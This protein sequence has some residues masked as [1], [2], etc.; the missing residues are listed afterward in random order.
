[1]N[2]L[3]F[4]PYLYDTVPGQRF[5][6]EQWARHLERQGIHC[7]F[8]PFETAALK[9]VLYE[10]RHFET[11]LKELGYS[12][13]RR[14]GQMTRRWAKWDL[15]YLYRELLPVGPTLLERWVAAQGIPVIY[16]FDDAIFLPA[17][18]PAN[19]RFQWLKQPQKT[20]EICR[21]STHV[22]V[23]NSYLAGYARRWTPKVTVIP[24][25]IDTDV[26]QPKGHVE[27]RGVPII[28][29]SGSLTTVEHLQTAAPVLQQLARRCQFRLRV[30]GSQTVR[31]DGVE[32]EAGP[33][34][35]G[36]EVQDL[37]AF[38]VGIM[39]LPDDPW[40]RG[41]CGLK[42]LQYMAL[43]IPTVASPVG[44]NEEIITDGVN[45]FLAGS[46]E[47]WID[48][49]SRL[50]EDAPLRARCAQ[51]ARRTVEQRYAAKI[52]V[53]RVIEVFEQASGRR[54]FQESQRTAVPASPE[55]IAT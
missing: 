45:G 14:L 29:W 4:T 42:A 22:I 17:A 30:I 6:I 38:D 43:G 3:V 9:D 50:L 39:P 27:I 5:R 51:E 26:Y 23:G 8:L 32:V 12:L 7:T 1:M 49:L 34:R 21:L 35:A 36:T 24:T 28:G 11:K 37:T 52:Q 46:P 47:E 16:D 55:V 54:S 33:W 20:G 41:K 10:T 48:K 40:A 25:T 31:I 18:S 53:P 13:A 44:V 15:I 2:V 19:Q